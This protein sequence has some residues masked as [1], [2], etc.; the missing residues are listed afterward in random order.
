MVLLAQKT[1]I[2]PL[3]TWQNPYSL[4]DLNHF[5]I[6]SSYFKMCARIGML[7]YPEIKLNRINE[8]FYP[9]FPKVDSG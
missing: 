4:P 8:A 1:E 5:L 9:V 2:P 3:L 6:L 7:R